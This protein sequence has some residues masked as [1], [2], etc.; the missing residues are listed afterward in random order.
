VP[1][2]VLTYIISFL[3]VGCGLGQNKFGSLGLDK[4]SESG[5]NAN[6][7]LGE[8]STPND[9][10]TGFD[11]L[12]NETPGLSLR[13]RLRM[14]DVE[15][16]EQDLV[17]ALELGKTELCRELEDLSCIRDVHNLNLGGVDAYHKNIFAPV[18]ESTATTPLIVERIVFSACEKRVSRDFSGGGI[19]FGSSLTTAEMTTRLYQ[20]AFLRD[21]H[22]AELSASAAFLDELKN[23]GAGSLQD[24]ALLSCAATFSS[25]EFLFY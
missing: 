18:D 14:K 11:E 5:T 20:R 3:L 1:L 10:E 22:E 21:P 19:I 15:R 7:Q 12:E 8:G 25:S 17:A 9:T 4:N 2:K 16:L 13:S 24:W 23:E 6:D